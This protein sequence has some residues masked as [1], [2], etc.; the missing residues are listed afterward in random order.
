MLRVDRQP[1]CWTLTLDR[2]EKANALCAELIEALIAALE[3]AESQ[4]VPVLAV[5]GNGRNFSA[6][7]DFAGYESQSE[8]DLLRRFVRIEMLLQAIDRSRALTVGLAH[9]RNFGAGV[10]LLAACRWRIAAP[11]AT[12]RMPGLGFGLVL[13]TR[14]FG[15]I[16]G[17]ERA[18][19]VLEGLETFGAER[20]LALGFL[21][22][23]AAQDEWPA[24]IAGAESTAATLTSENRALLY[25]ALES[26]TRDADLADLVR[27]VCSGGLKDRIR[28]YLKM[29][30]N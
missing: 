14:R 12:F 5:R 29:G 7:F 9:G 15:A 24:V 20:A 2:P 21:R 17:R 19:E 6:G 27:S 25:R 18:R 22:Q 1:S 30:P 28:G 13:G 8:G 10:D 11:D 16:V 26:P 23:V 3:E 4:D